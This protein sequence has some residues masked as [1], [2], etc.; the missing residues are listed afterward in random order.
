M[1][2]IENDWRLVLKFSRRL[3]IFLIDD[4]IYILYSNEP[5]KSKIMLFI[6]STWERVIFFISDFE[7]FGFCFALKKNLLD[8]NSNYVFFEFDKKLKS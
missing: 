4:L 8:I 2:W 1:I 5:I 6:A 3:K 7:E